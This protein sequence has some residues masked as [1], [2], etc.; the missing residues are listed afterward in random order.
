MNVKQPGVLYT[1]LDANPQSQ[2]VSST[3][4]MSWKRLIPQNKKFHCSGSLGNGLNLTVLLIQSI[5][6]AGIPYASSTMALR[7]AD[8]V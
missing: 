8:L 7:V 4:L 6:I 5:P 1:R 2:T 3:V